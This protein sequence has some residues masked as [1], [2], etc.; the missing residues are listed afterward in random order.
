MKNIYRIQRYLGIG[1]MVFVTNANA[2]ERVQEGDAKSYSPYASRVH[3]TNVYWGDTHV[4]TSWSIDANIRGKNTRLSPDYAYR[5][6]RGETIETHN[7]MG[8]RLQRPLDFLVVADHAEGIGLKPLLDAKDPAIMKTDSGRRFYKLLQN[9]AGNPDMEE[10]EK[11][12]VKSKLFSALWTFNPET[13]GPDQL[14]QQ[15]I[16]NN[17]ANNA[18]RYNQP[19][20]FTAF[21]GY[22][23]TAS[24][25]APESGAIHRVVIFADAADKAT[26]MLPFTRNDSSD[27]EDLWDYM[28][29]YQ[30]KTG[31][32]ILAIPH[33]PNLTS[34]LMFSSKNFSGQ[35]LTSNY[36][37]MRS[38][39]EPLVEVTQTKGDSEAHPF[40]S[41]TDEFADFETWS[42]WWYDGGEANNAAGYARPALKRG[43]QLQSK[44]GVNPFKFGMIGST[45]VH[46]SL[47]TADDNNF[48]G[49]HP[50]T[51]PSEK[52]ILSETGGAMGAIPMWKISASGYAGVWATE[53]TRESLFAAMKRKEVYSSTGPRMTVR[54]FG[55]W[56]YQSDDAYKPDFAEIGYEKG[57]P[58]GGDLTNAPLDRAPSFLI[59]A[60]RDPDSA[61]LDRVQVIK[62]WHNKNGELHEK[63]Y[64][65][66]LSDDRKPSWRGKVK[67]VGSTVDVK[68]ASYTNTIGD[69]ELS[70]VWR[71][72]DFNKNE[73]AFYY[74]RVLEIP[75]PRWP[76]YDAK[77]F[78]LEDIPKDVSMITQERAYSSPIWYTPTTDI[79]GE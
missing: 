20:V 9:I 72:P 7:G 18:D 36:A 12:K 25:T 38:R 15:S 23:W 1:F 61:N 47:T 10:K 17:V 79:G 77:F 78:G 59:R 8:A 11:E 60:V 51:A 58:M 67:P 76:A 45:D 14:L 41:P 52:R 46:T 66:A 57:V 21:T 3:P 64:N 70:V 37:K 24:T 13:G 74:V 49:K 33:N 71:D 6:A 54:F 62:G 28:G 16:W 69:S 68:D 39:W 40:L 44:L 5:F 4:H 19:G 63:I 73:L 29:Q 75:T 48:W 35:P 43:L 65:V 32:D 55:G 27:P 26:A 53:N 56:D 22:E 34:G 50:T 30:K 42:S 2:L 31:G